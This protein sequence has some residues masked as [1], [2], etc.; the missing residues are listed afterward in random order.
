MDIKKIEYPSM[1]I[2]S[3]NDNIDVFF[4]LENDR[5]YCLTIA[6]INWVNKQVTNNG[7]L[8]PSVYI[9]ISE[10]SDDNIKKAVN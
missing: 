2:D 6:T 7:Y 8:P 9:I 3:L 4:T 10:F 5:S 1:W